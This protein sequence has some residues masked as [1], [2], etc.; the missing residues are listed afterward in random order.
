MLIEGEKHVLANYPQDLSIKAEEQLKALGVE[1]HTGMRVTD[2]QPGYVIASGQ[3]IEAAVT[4]WAAGVQASPLGKRLGL[5]TDKRGCVM[6]NATLNPEGHPEI[7]VCGD[8][9]QLKR[10]A[11]RFPASLSPRCRW[12]ITSRG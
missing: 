10:T 1:V 12:A 6:V 7:F 3:R 5:P 2:V 8:L 4:L 11:A 9:A